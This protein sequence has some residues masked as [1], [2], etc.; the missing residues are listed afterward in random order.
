[1]LCYL[2]NENYYLNNNNKQIYK[3]VFKSRNDI[4]QQKL[5][6]ASHFKTQMRLNKFGEADLQY[7]ASKLTLKYTG[8]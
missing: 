2:N 4:S 3:W 6:I 8:S 7:S 1:M 5:P